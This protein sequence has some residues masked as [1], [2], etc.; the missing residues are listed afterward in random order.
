MKLINENKGT[1]TEKELETILGEDFNKNKKEGSA[2]E[3]IFIQAGSNRT[4]K[5]TNNIEVEVGSNRTPK[6]TNNIEVVEDN[7]TTFMI[8]VAIVVLIICSSISVS[9]LLVLKK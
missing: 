6:P 8:I 7:S 2:R 5:P 9:I 4:P 1:L 3:K